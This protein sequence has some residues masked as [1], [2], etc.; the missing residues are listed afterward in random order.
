M[1]LT[2]GILARSRKPNERRL[3]LHPTQLERIPEELRGAVS[4]ET[5]YGDGYGWSDADLAA[6]GVQ[7]L[8]RPELLAAVEVVVLPKPLA[9]DLEALR[10]GQVL[11]GWPHCVQDAPLTQAA[12]DRKLTLIAWEAMN[13]W[14]R[15]GNYALHVFHKN[16]ELAGYCSV[17]HAL[18]LVG[19][20][21]D[22]GRPL[23]AAVI[24]FGAT[25]RGAV[26]ALGALGVQDVTVLTQRDVAAVAA[27]FASMRLVGFERDADDP[28]RARALTA[29]GGSRPLVEELAESDVIVNCVLQ[30]TD[31]PLRFVSDEEL[32][33]LRPGTL[34]VDVSV[35]TGMGFDWAHAT[36][37][38]APLEVVGDRVHYYAVDHSPSLLW[39]SASSE[40]G[41]ALLSHLP[42]VMAGPDAWA[43]DPTIDRAIEIQD[44]VVRNPRILTFQHRAP[45]YPHPPA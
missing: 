29:D 20:T 27:P 35:D 39:D 12:I 22:Y 1:T 6:T 19:R 18:Q 14:D 11:W 43:A 24:S 16:N 8:P 37:F 5:G 10:E 31:N 2:L 30:D 34:V 38:D 28:A 42:T 21:G 23:R 15:D 33:L 13:H 41:A 9:A 32:A 45:D 3:A 7:V 36:T 40:I 17:S 25:A 26:R 44:G 4:L